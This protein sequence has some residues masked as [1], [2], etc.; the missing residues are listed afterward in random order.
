MN[1]ARTIKQ[2]LQAPKPRNPLVPL[3]A[4]R[5]AGK[6]QKSNKAVRAI[7]KRRIQQEMDPQ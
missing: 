7:L 4:Q 6:H 3:A 1:S 5:K 2:R